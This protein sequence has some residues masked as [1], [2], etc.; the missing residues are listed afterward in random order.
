MTRAAVVG[1]TLTAGCCEYTA[2]ADGVLAVLMPAAG[3]LMHNE[4]GETGMPAFPLA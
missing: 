4:E 3:W 2:G 1:T